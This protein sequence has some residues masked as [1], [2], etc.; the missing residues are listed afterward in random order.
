MCNLTY[1][2]ACLLWTFVFLAEYEPAT[3][4][5]LLMN[6]YGINFGKDTDDEFKGKIK[7]L[8]LE[9][10]VFLVA[11]VVNIDLILNLLI[12]ILRDLYNLFQLENTIIEYKE[13]RI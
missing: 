12:F 10:V 7:D 1:I 6:P 3:I 8:N 4:T 11:I 2:Y 9:Y 13:K 5:T